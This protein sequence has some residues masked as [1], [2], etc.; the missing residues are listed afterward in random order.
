MREQLRNVKQI[1]ASAGAF[2]AILESGSVVTWGHPSAGGD[3]SQVQDQLSLNL[4]RNLDANVGCRSVLKE[5]FICL[6]STFPRGFSLSI[7]G[8]HR[9]RERLPGS[10]PRKAESTWQGGARRFLWGAF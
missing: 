5:A 7:A 3:S 8:I 4:G 10:L 9:W 6:V 2:A 1:Q